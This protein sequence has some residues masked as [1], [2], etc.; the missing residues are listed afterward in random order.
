MRFWE[1]T[2][3][4]TEFQAHSQNFLGFFCY[5][6]QLPVYLLGSVAECCPLGVTAVI[7][8]RA[9][10]ATRERLPGLG[11]LAVDIPS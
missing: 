8:L 2:V 1:G 6:T 7:L 9:A 5:R 10:V 11:L 4:F 3:S